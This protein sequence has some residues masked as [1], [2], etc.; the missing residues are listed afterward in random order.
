MR[1]SSFEIT[2]TPG[3]RGLQVRLTLRTDDGPEGVSEAAAGTPPGLLISTLECFRRFVV[4]SD[5]ADSARLVRTLLDQTGAPTGRTSATAIGMIEVASR[6]IEAKGLGIPLHRLLGGSLRDRVRL[7]ATDWEPERRT[8]EAFSA[9]A[10]KVVSSGYRSIKLAPFGDS[11]ARATR[12]ETTQTLRLCEAVRAA[13]GPDVDL[14]IDLGS[15][16]REDAIRFARVVERIDPAGLFDVFRLGDGE[17]L[18]KMPGGLGCPLAVGT[19]IHHWRDAVEAVRLPGA[20]LI[21][22]NPIEACGFGMSQ[23]IAA[24]AEAHGVEIGLRSANGETALATTLQLA[25]ALPGL[26]FVEH[27][28]AGDPD[29]GLAGMV[30]GHVLIDR[31]NPS[32]LA[33]LRVSPNI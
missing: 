18:S 7:S 32:E 6:L 23:T 31:G 24:L 21:R 29:Q 12:T 16:P 8:T 10:T 3:I 30:D 13:V 14:W 2:T 28:I 5:S 11:G 19:G 33:D 20:R 9:A 27:S 22:F 26:R 17:P 1:I 15:H 4:E 25:A